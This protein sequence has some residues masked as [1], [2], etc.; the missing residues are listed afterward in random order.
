M[1]TMR[2]R[3]RLP[4]GFWLRM[5]CF[6]VFAFLSLPL[7]VSFLMA[8][9][10][11]ATLAMPQGFSLRW[12]ANLYADDAWTAAYRTSIVT[13]AGA[14][15]IAVV[16]GGLFAFANSRFT[17]RMRL[18]LST[19][20][21]A[22]LGIPS[23]IIGV[24]LLLI[25]NPLGLQGNLLALTMAFTAVA[26]PYVVR[27]IG[28][29]LAI[30]DRTVEEAALTLGANEIQTFFLITVP[31]IAPGLLSA[32]ILAFVFAFGNLQIAVFLVGIDTTT[33]PAMMYSVL[34]FGPDPTVAAAAVTNILIV[35][36]AI[37]IGNRLVGARNLMRL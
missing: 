31:A 2:K 12:F 24:G 5:L 34:E 20:S 3:R 28:A 23:I 30:Y 36:L 25:A 26:M 18:P 13:A 4:E 17:Y 7:F 16:T 33:V 15:V 27:T 19:F 11:Q 35:A 14:A 22:P 1:S 37:I 10:P 8:V 9:N 32:T 6:A 21:L 29:S